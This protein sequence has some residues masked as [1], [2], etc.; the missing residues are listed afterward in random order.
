MVKAVAT[1]NSVNVLTAQADGT[2]TIF[3]TV[4]VNNSGVGLAWSADAPVT[5]AQTIPQFQTAAKNKI[6]DDCAGR[7]VT[8]TPADVI[9]FATPF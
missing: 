1:I 5:A 6:V 3:Y 4:A 7:G 2:F 8:L 9:I